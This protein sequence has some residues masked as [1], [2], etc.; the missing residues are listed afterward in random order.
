VFLQCMCMSKEDSA[1][2]PEN[3]EVRGRDSIANQSGPIGFSHE[4]TTSSSSYSSSIVEQDHKL[5]RGLSLRP[6][7]THYNPWQASSSP[8]EP[9]HCRV[10]PVANSLHH[11]ISLSTRS[12]PQP[13]FALTYKIFLM[14]T[15]SL[16]EH[17]RYLFVLCFP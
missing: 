9:R 7:S 1:H 3:P 10:L 4:F 13:R 16:P 8:T 14:P 2:E 15:T 5:P 17:R 11:G 6:F 12:S